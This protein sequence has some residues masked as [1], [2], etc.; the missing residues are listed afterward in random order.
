MSDMKN[1]ALRCLPASSSSLGMF[2]AVR[3]VADSHTE[4][5]AGSGSKVDELPSF[6]WLQNGTAILDDERLPASQQTF[7]SLDPV[8]GKGVRG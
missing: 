1:C 6:V 2:Q 4:W 8:T 7:E 5:V 3:P